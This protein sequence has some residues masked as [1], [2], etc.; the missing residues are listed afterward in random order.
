MTTTTDIIRYNAKII[1]GCGWAEGMEF[2]GPGNPFLL[3]GSKGRGLRPSPSARP[4][5]ASQKEHRER[6]IRRANTMLRRKVKQLYGLANGDLYMLTLTYAENV[7]DYDRAISDIRNFFQRLRRHIGR[8]AGYIAVPERQKRG[9]WH[10]HII[11]DV[12]LYHSVWAKLWGHG[13]IWVKKVR[14]VKHASRYVKKYL[15]KAFEAEEGVPMGKH[16]YLV[17]KGLNWEEI[18]IATDDHCGTWVYLG[19]N[20]E[21]HLV[22]LFSVPEEQFIW[23][24]ANKKGEGSSGV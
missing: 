16:R 24:E 8:S 19:G 17:S 10:W 20:Q 12:Y 9:A 23:W 7:I 21:Y 4:C 22:A 6:A 3:K 13:F 11:I 18:Y 1:K 15:A 5:P 14:D 2:H